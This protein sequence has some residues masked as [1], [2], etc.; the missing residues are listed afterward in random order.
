VA[1]ISFSFLLD[2]ARAD[3]EFT[4]WGM[5]VDEVQAASPK[6]RR[7]R[8]VNEESQAKSRVSVS[9]GRSAAMLAGWL[10]YD[11]QEVIAQFYF[12]LETK[13]LVS[14]NLNL[15]P[16][17]AND[18]LSSITQKYGD[19]IESKDLSENYYSRAWVHEGDRIVFLRTPG[20]AK[21]NFFPD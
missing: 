13:R 1:A 14:V 4:R 18:F 6:D 20:T 9:D 8:H 12:D 15:R 16:L 2:E 11:N 7:L 3:W 21:L 10:S 5:T 19:P 17:G